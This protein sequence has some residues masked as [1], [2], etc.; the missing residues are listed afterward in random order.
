MSIFTRIRGIGAVAASAAALLAWAV[1]ADAGPRAVLE[2]FTS[3]GCSSCPPADRLLGEY[4]NQDDVIALSFSVD[5]WDYLGWKDT[6]AS[7]DYSQRQRDYAT[8]RGDRKVYTPQV[9]VNGA[10]HAVGSNQSSIESAIRSVDGLPI[11]VKLVPDG[12]VIHLEIG[13]A[14]DDSPDRAA[15]WLAVFD[16]AVTVDIG[17]GENRSRSITY[18]NAVRKLH[19]VAMWKGKPMSIDLPR[20]EINPSQHDG[21]AVLLQ[22]E[23]RS[24]LP[25]HVIGAAM[26]TTPES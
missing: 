21:C 4:I 24:G 12:D 14:T 7:P 17:R 5:Y 23:S 15:I 22:A 25:G 3:Q 1:P 16:R 26:V 2:L 20:S 9:V 10:R 19:R 11:D 18:N 8:A 13:A 6:L